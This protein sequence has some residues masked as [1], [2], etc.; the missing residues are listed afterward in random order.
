[1]TTEQFSALVRED[2]RRMM[3]R[4]FHHCVF[5]WDQATGFSCERVNYDTLDVTASSWIVPGTIQEEED[6]E[7]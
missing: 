5:E 7:L 4:R 6:N 3:P 2:I 1:M